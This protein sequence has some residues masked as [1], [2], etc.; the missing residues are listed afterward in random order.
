MK[1]TESIVRYIFSRQKEGRTRTLGSSKMYKIACF[2]RDNKDEFICQP[3]DS[4]VYN[5]HCDPRLRILELLCISVI[6]PL[7]FQCERATVLCSRKPSIRTLLK[8]KH[9]HSREKV[10]Q[11]CRKEM[12]PRKT[13]NE[14]RVIKRINQTQSKCHSLIIPS[15]EKIAVKDQWCNLRH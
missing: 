3:S 11:I 10:I 1:S 7:F 2:Q 15:Q 9:F 8:F 6:N 12:I 13:F 4:Q 14:Q 5:I